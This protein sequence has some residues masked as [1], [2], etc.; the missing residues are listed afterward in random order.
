[1]TPPFLYLGLKVNKGL[2][3]ARTIFSILSSIFKFI[4]II[5]IAKIAL[6]YGILR[7]RNN[8]WK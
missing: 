6:K 2:I 5:P 4:F 7:L 8:F 1:M 3:L